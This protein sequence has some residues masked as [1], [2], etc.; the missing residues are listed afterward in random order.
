VER[1]GDLFFCDV[2]DSDDSAEDAEQADFAWEAA[3]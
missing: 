3:L 2:I 1:I